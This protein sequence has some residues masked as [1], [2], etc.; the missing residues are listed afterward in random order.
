MSVIFDAKEQLIT[1]LV[2]REL[3]GYR[4]TGLPSVSDGTSHAIGEEFLNLLSASRSPA[5]SLANP[6]TGEANAIGAGFAEAIETF[7]RSCLCSPEALAI[8]RENWEFQR[9]KI[10]AGRQ[11]AHLRLLER[12]DR[13]ATRMKVDPVPSKPRSPKSKV[14]EREALAA[15]EREQL[16]VLL[17]GE[18]LVDADLLVLIPPKDHG[19][20]TAKR[21]GGD[22]LVT[23][24]ELKS[25]RSPLTAA[26]GEVPLCHANV[27]C[28]FTLR[29]DRGQNVRTEAL[30]LA[31]QR[32]GPM[33]RMVVATAEVWPGRLESLGKGTGEIDC[34]YHLSLP[35]LERAVRRVSPPEVQRQLELLIR[36][37]RLRDIADLPLDL[38]Q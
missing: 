8:R 15:E 2:A 35:L 28:K 17:H 10:Y 1:D 7:L 27:S 37:D 38:L 25:L 22:R 3:L 6:T 33:P 19:Q 31:R 32:R 18:Y 14:A 21:R 5:R 24:D 4:S 36:A 29:N 16:E 12:L 9:G 30:Q 13:D 34:V 26:P 11:Y 20:L 23:A